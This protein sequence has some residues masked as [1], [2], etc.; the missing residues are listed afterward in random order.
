MYAM[1]CHSM[2]C[3]AITV[4]HNIFFP[5]VEASLATSLVIVGAWIGSLLGS[6]PSQLYGKRIVLLAN[7][8]FFIAGA[9]MSASGNIYAL[10]IGRFISG[11]GVGVASGVP[12]VLLS[13]I[14]SADTRGTITTLHP[15]SLL[16]WIDRWMDGCLTWS[17]LLHHMLCCRSWS[18]WVSS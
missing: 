8:A 9:A 12:S 16:V 7:N 18:L 15:V 13:E 10:F 5:S 4:C 6:G 17:S 2:L 11:L 14:A 1:L 3:S